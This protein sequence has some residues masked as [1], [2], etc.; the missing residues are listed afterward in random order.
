MYII[1][2]DTDK[3]LVSVGRVRLWEP[4]TPIEDSAYLHLYDLG[5]KPTKEKKLATLFPDLTGL[6]DLINQPII[7][8]LY[9]DALIE[10]YS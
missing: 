7:K 8:L 10:E 2:L 5:Y 1:K 3:Y 9:P 4:I 6:D